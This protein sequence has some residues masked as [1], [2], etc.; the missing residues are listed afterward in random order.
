[1]RISTISVAAYTWSRV[2]S[3]ARRIIKKS[4]NKALELEVNLAVFIIVEDTESEKESKETR[5]V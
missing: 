3:K 2:P 1:M 4:R 5:D